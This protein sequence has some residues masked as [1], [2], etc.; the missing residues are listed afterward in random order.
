MTPNLSLEPLAADRSVGRATGR[1]A[2]QAR[3]YLLHGP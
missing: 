3:C 2:A 1:L